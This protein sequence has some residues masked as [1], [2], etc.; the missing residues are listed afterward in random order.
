MQSNGGYRYPSRRI[1]LFLT[2]LSAV[3]T[4]VLWYLKCLPFSEAVSLLFA[5]EGTSLLAA[6]YSPVGLVPPQGSFWSRVMWFIRTQK[7][8]SVS[9]EQPMFYGGLLLLFL[10]YVITSWA[11]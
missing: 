9:F 7:G 4:G 6:A 8:I 3:V 2:S 11:K 10:S 5:L 1:C